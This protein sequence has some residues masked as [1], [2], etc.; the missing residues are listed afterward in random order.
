[1]SVHCEA[2]SVLRCPTVLLTDCT[3]AIVLTSHL[4]AHCVYVW[5]VL[6]TFYVLSE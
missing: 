3:P 2:H 5:R 6:E 1:M 4:E